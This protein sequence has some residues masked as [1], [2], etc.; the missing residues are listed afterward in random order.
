ME[1]QSLRPAVVARE[2]PRPEAPALQVPADR[3]TA[4]PADVAKLAQEVERLREAV[5]RLQAAPT[6]IEAAREAPKAEVAGL[7]DL[8]PFS[9]FGASYALPAYAFGTAANALAFTA[10][11]GSGDAV[12]MAG[13][14]AAQLFHEPGQA[15]AVKLLSSVGNDP[16]VRSSMGIIGGVAAGV[17]LMKGIHGFCAASDAHSKRG[18]VVAALDVAAGFATGLGCVPGHQALGAGSSMALMALAGLVAA[19]PA[20]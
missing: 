8:R 4:T 12:R 20:T 6:A 15:G 2:Q 16:G 18:M 7:A 9:P 14:G 5:S 11:M 19:A 17:L 10:V 1:V 3:V 13:E